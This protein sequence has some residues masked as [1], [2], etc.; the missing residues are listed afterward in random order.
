MTVSF[1]ANSQ[2]TSKITITSDQLRVA[3]LIFVEHAE[4][5]KLIPLL[6]Q[7]NANLQV[8]NN[9]WQRTD[10]LKTLQMYRQNQIMTQQEESMKYLQKRL[11]ASQTIG[12][13][14][15]GVSIIAVVLCLLLK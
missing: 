5:T 12:G 3:N 2:D 13:T 4:Y 7:E 14:A 10:S 6:K 9:T 11:H 15:V 1:S 8:I